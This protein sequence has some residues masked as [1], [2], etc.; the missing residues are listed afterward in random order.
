MKT[1]QALVLALL[2]M[3]CSLPSLAHDASTAEHMKLGFE[4]GIVIGLVLGFV[5]GVI[6]MSYLYK[7]RLQR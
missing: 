2:F 1:K 4:G 3:Y 6:L 5:S 7:S